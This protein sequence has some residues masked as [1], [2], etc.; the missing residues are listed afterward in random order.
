MLLPGLCKVN[1]MPENV[2]YIFRHLI[3]IHLG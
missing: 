3:E 2:F 1:G